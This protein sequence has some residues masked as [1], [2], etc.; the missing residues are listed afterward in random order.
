MACL[1]AR[2]VLL[3]AEY[4]AEIKLELKQSFASANDAHLSDD[5]AVA[6]MGHPVLRWLGF[7][8]G[9]G[10]GGVDQGLGFGLDLL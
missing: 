9:L 7:V 10:D 2:C 8:V 6:K 1:L 4:L 3:S 5:E